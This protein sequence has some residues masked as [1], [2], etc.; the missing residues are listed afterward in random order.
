MHHTGL[1]TDP[2]L[3]D[4]EG[5]GGHYTADRVTTGSG[6]SGGPLVV[7]NPSSSKYELA[8]ILVSGSDYS[9]DIWF[10]GVYALGSEALNAAQDALGIARSGLSTR[11]SNWS[12]GWIKNA[13]QTFAR[14]SFDFRGAPPQT[15]EVSLSLDIRTGR[16]GDID[17]YVRSPGGRVRVVAWRNAN[18]AVQ[19]LELSDH[20]ITGGM[21]YANGR[22]I[23]T[24]FFRDVLPGNPSW[25]NGASMRIRSRWTN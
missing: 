15:I 5:Q 22:G 13:S 24:L 19:D 20:D 10:A 3:D 11:R 17:A 16:R 12:L 4:Q 2:F 6:N 23:W 1:F 7:W 18:D 9:D 25:F 14:R 21:L 8:G